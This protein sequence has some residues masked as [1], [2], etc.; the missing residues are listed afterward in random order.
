MTERFF[1]Y[2]NLQLSDRETVL[3]PLVLRAAAKLQTLPLQQI[4][5]AGIWRDRSTYFLNIAY[6]SMQAMN[7]VSAAEVISSN[8][9]TNGNTVA[10]YTHVPFC[11]AECYYCHYYKKFGQSQDHIDE[12]LDGIESE[13]E[14]QERRFGGLKAASVYVGGGTPSYMNADQIDRLFTTMKSHVAIPAGTEISFE[15]HP[16][17]VTDDRLAVLE[18]HG[19][20]RINIGVESFNDAILA[21]ENRRHTSADAIAAFQ[22]AREAGFRNINL[23]LIYGLKGQTVPL[24]EESLDQIAKLQ[25]AST[26]MYYLRL[27]RGTPEFKLWKKDPSTFPTDYEL[28]LMHAMNFERMEGE[29]GYTQN[30]TD[31][32]I[33]DSSFFHT[34]Q[35]HN[36]RKTDEIDLL[37][38]GPSAYSYVGGVDGVDGWQYYNVNDTGKWQ[39]ALKRGELPIWKG[40]HL[41]DDEPMRRTVMLGIKMGMDRSA[42][43][44]TYGIDVVDAFPETWERLKNLGLVEIKSE[45][46][47]LTYAGKLFADEVGQQFYS[48]AMKGRMAA[49]DPELVS[50][51][52]PQFNP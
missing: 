40:E 9:K 19:V 5:D 7:D 42:F 22:R 44:K 14:A 13:L 47:D 12:Y 36:W 32:F 41:T 50:T 15:M 10:L 29:L 31:W 49:I 28:S 8:S 1:S 2:Q 35:D 11:T 48:D 39:D 33:R 25:P 20:N 43:V 34:Y 24:W 38:I 3:S 4:K 16:E 45:S 51:T 30:P 17:S 23:D 6:P 26:T 27:K 46:I 18:E 37:G 52:W 21:D